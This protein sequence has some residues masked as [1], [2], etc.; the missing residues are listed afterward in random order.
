MAHQLVLVLDFGSQYTQLIARRIREQSVYCEIHP[1]TLAARRRSARWRPSAHRALGRPDVGLRRG[2]ADGRRASSSS[3][4]CRCSA[5]ATALQ[6]IAQAARRQGRAPAD[7]REYGRAHVERT[8]RRA[9]ACSDASPRGEELDGVD[10][11]RRPRRRA[12][13][14]FVHI[15]ETR[16]LRRFAA[17]AQRE[18]ARSTASSSTP[19]SCTRRAAPSCSATSCSASCGAV[20]RLDDG[21]VRRRGG[22][23]DPRRRSARDGRVH[24]R[25]VGR[26]RLVGRGGAAPQARSA[27]G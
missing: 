1:Y 20:G 12:A 25:P 27:T 6:L 26:R 2:R 19:R 22:R 23:A 10:V 11:A 8:Q 24:L 17:V 9:R 14:G 4:A 18:R 13:A 15:A 16:E 3:S 7:K 5:S 21:V